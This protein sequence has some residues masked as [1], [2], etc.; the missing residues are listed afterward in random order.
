MQYVFS[1]SDDGLGLK[2]YLNEEIGRLKQV[3][4]DSLESEEVKSDP[5]MLESTKKVINVMESYRKQGVNEGMVQQ[6]LKIQKLA[7]EIQFNG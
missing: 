1:F 6:I 7:R 2:T 3:V 5:T 4:K